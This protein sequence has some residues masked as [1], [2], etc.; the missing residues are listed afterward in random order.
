MGRQMASPAHIRAKPDGGDNTMLK[1]DNTVLVVIDVQGNLA[2][3]MYNKENLFENL[4]RAIRGAKALKMPV[5]W[6]E[7][8]PEKLGPTLPEIAELLDSITPI[9]KFTFS[10]CDTPEFVQALEATGRKQVLI[11]GIESH[12]CV[13]QTSVDLVKAGY[14]VHVIADCVSSRTP[15]NRQIGLDKI[16]AAGGEIT[17]VETALFEILRAA[18]GQ[19]FRDIVKIVK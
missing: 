15:E 11:T 3:A 2:Q 9:S 7:Q 10:S 13:Y 17:S 16:K 12:I 19:I 6:L 18:E 8:I 5:L 1:Q 4:K 14:E